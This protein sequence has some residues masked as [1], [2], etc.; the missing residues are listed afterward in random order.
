MK[1]QAE[2]L[3]N[4]SR[5]DVW[6]IFDD[7]DSMK[8]WQPTLEK[9]EH[10]SGER[11]QPG[12][13]SRLTYKE[14]G[15]DIVLMESIAVRKQPDFVSGSYSSSMGTNHLENHFEAVGPRSNALAHGR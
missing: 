9:F 3:I 11:G 2:V 6:K 14:N 5:E 4:R 13:V 10:V 8:K 15:R 1:F 12:A 7:P